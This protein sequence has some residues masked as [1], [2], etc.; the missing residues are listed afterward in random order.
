MRATDNEGASRELGARRVQIVN[1]GQNLPPFGR[2]DYPLDKA[3]L[4]CDDLRRLSFTLP[5]GRDPGNVVAG[6]ALTWGPPS[7]ADSVSYVELLLDGAI[8][9]NTR[10]DCV[11]PDEALINCYGLNRPDVARELLGLRQRAT[12]PGST[13]RSA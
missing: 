12:T 13:S 10:T 11:Q 2:I 8:I 4:F 9:A 5:A 1:N 7:I 6:W 3:S